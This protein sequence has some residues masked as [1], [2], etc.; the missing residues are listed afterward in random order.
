MPA[1]AVVQLKIADREPFRSFIVGVGSAL[2]LFAG[3]DESALPEGVRAGIEELRSAAQIMAGSLP[4]REEPKAGCRGAVIIEWPAPP[5]HGV[6]GIVGQMVAVYDAFTG[7]EPAP[8]PIATV[9]RIGLHVSMDEM[10]TAYVTLFADE[11]GN[12]VLDGEPHVRDGEIL[13]GTFRF[14]V[15]EMRVRS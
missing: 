11:D 9:S 12:P 7:D 4:P 14:L 10:V 2:E 6:G 5:Q 15:A 3:A 13:T 8:K 1:E